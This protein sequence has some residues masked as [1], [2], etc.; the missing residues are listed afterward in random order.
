MVFSIKKYHRKFDKC[1]K[2]YIIQYDSWAPQCEFLYTKYANHQNH[3]ARE[4][5][6]SWTNLTQPSE[7][8]SA[9]K[10]SCNHIMGAKIFV[11][12]YIAKHSMLKKR[13]M[14][15]SLLV[16][17]VRKKC[18]SFISHLW[19]REQSTKD[20]FGL[21]PISKKRFWVETLGFWSPVGAA[22]Q[23]PLL[24]QAIKR[25]W[26]K[27][28]APFIT[29]FQNKKSSLFFCLVCELW[30]LYINHLSSTFIKPGAFFG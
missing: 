4:I 15:P 16:A 29:N 25:A 12:E 8:V 5:T 11:P 18:L 20:N 1:Y 3:S 23:G 7:P 30:P 13:G 24:F 14:I 27:A 28:S 19:L 22:F 21:K 2:Q 10:H 6:N 26:Q 17:L 9:M